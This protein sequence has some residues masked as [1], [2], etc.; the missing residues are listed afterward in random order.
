MIT[1]FKLFESKKYPKVGDYV[2]CELELWSS[3][4]K[5]RATNF[6]NNTIGRIVDEEDAFDSI[7]S[8][9]KHKTYKIEFFGVPSEIVEEYF[10]NAFYSEITS[11]DEAM[12][13]QFNS[14]V[15]FDDI[16]YWSEDKKELERILIQKRFDL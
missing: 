6:L 1:I 8:K 4:V 14:W 16:R 12:N 3:P 9:R 2:I 7:V 11:E 15:L 10:S 5:E 13:A